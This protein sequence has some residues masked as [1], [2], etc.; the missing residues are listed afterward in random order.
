[1]GVTQWAGGDRASGLD[2]CA[3]YQLRNPSAVR[4]PPGRVDGQHH[5]PPTRVPPV[6]HRRSHVRRVRSLRPFLLRWDDPA[7][8]PPE[9]FNAGY[10]DSAEE[11]PSKRWPRSTRGSHPGVNLGHAATLA[12]HAGPAACDRQ[13]RRRPQ[14][15]GSAEGTLLGLPRG[16]RTLVPRQA[17]LSHDRPTVPHGSVVSGSRP[18]CRT[19][20]RAVGLKELRSTPQHGRVQI[21]FERVENGE[22]MVGPSRFHGR[23]GEATVRSRTR[24]GRSTLSPKSPQRP[25]RPVS[26]PLR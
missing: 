19:V 10:E 15:T 5:R 2:P 18:P 12:T 23:V 6:H 8:R 7:G 11:T 17:Q 25:G 4:R 20:E 14:G 16:S 1:M 24:A 9:G 21:E 26:P 3:P 13:L 22:E